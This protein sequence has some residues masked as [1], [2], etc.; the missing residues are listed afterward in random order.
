MDA[1]PPSVTIR[2]ATDADAAAVRSLVQS[3]L[4]EYGLAADP[5]GVDADL[6]QLERLYLAAGGLFEVVET[7]DGRI[8]GSCGLY[9]LC[10]GVVELRK[11]Y[12]APAFRGRGLGRL[13][14]ER[15]LAWCRDHGVRRVELETAGVLVE[16][17]GLYRSYGFRPTTSRHLASRCDRAYALDV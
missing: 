8:I 17:I 14:M 5:D 3:V 9:P 15:A 13:L 6:G 2:P 1:T 11:M 16:A 12:L 10:E 4:A 7:A